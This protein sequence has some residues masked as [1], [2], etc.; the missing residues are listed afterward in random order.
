MRLIEQGQ[1]GLTLVVPGNIQLKNR[2]NLQEI[3]TYHFG[4]K[5]RGNIR[6]H[7]WA[8]QKLF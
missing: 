3:I 2:V 8:G 6:L 5:N 7:N 4:G 1:S